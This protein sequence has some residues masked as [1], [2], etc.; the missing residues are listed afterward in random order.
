MCVSGKICVDNLNLLFGLVH[1]HIE[2]G[3]KTNIIVTL[4]DLFNRYP[5]TLNERVKEM[6]TLLHDREVHVR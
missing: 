5:N 6:F 2:F 4:A 3:V 1:S